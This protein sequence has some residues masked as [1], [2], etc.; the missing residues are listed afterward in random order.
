[1]RVVIP[2]MPYISAKPPAGDV[3]QIFRAGRA[4][5]T[6]RHEKIPRTA[7]PI[8]GHLKFNLSSASGKKPGA[9]ATMEVG[10]LPV[11]PAAGGVSDRKSAV[12]AD[13]YRMAKLVTKQLETFMGD[14]K[15]IS[16]RRGSPQAAAMRLDD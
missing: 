5:E 2:W 11:G 13:A 10:S 4:G 14:Q 16:N 15:W 12:E 9:V 3:A 6:P 8:A 7:H 1:M